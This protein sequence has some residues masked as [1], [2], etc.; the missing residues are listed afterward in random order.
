MKL[1]LTIPAV[2]GI[3]LVLLFSACSKDKSV[4]PNQK[5]SMNAVPLGKCS[6][7]SILAST[8][9]DSK[10]KTIIYGDLGLSPGIAVSGFP[11]GQL[12]GVLRVNDEISNQATLDLSFA[13]ID[14]E[15]RK[16]RHMETLSGNIG[17]LT[18]SPGLYNSISLL[19]ISSGDLTFDA[20]GDE[21][22]IF[23]IQISTSFASLAGTKIIL[24]NGASASNIFW[25]VS[26]SANFG[27]NSQMQGTFIALESITF[28]SGATLHGRALSRKGFIS[29]EGNIVSLE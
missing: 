15:R 6:N 11:P 27:S 16:S 25:Q 28:D 23:I 1:K 12:N 22:A 14:A 24:I 21:N 10:G 19:E 4:M 13:Y 26:N 2:L 8:F 5:I 17:G 7:F 3:S 20:H 18:L 29:L 9:V